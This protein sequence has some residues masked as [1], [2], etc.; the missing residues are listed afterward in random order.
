MDFMAPSFTDIVSGILSLESRDEG[1][2]PVARIHSILHAIKPHEP[3]LSTLQFSIVGDVC[4][5][6]KVDWAIGV[7]VDRGV[8]KMVGGDAV[9]VERPPRVRTRFLTA[10]SYSQFH[11]VRSASRRFY[12]R[13]LAE[14]PEL[15]RKAAQG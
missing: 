12:E 5:S 10:L 2:I 3:I 9:S 14:L 13:L 7:L 11:A 4:Y 15:P 6:R 1:A 8:L